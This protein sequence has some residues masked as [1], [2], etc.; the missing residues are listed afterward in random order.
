MKRKNM[1]CWQRGPASGI[2]AMPSANKATKLCIVGWHK[3]LLSE[4]LQSQTTD[5]YLTH[6][7][8]TTHFFFIYMSKIFIYHM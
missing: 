1:E 3:V 7:I 8:I 5:P 6:P 2:V 4:I